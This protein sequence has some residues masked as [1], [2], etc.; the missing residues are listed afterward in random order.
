MKNR[1]KNDGNDDK[2]E[3]T[4]ELI[5]KAKEKQLFIQKITA[6]LEKG[7]VLLI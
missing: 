3:L 6:E 4:N 7:V 5:G 2:S 1:I